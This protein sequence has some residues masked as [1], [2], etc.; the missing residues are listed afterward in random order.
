[1]TTPK[2][3][4]ARPKKAT[5]GP[6]HNM[7]LDEFD[8]LLN[9]ERG[10]PV[11]FAATVKELAVTRAQIKQLDAARSEVF[12]HVKRAYELG[13]RVVG[14]TG[15]ELR[16]T[17][18]GEPS[19]Y[20]AVAS[21]VAKKADPEAWRRAQA[22]KRWVQVKCPPAF[23]LAIPVI[24]TP[25]V[26]EFLPPDQA[27]ILYREHPAWKRRRW[28]AQDEER[29][30]GSL[31]KIA[32]EFGW[33]GGE[34]DGPVTFTDGWSVQLRTTQYS[35]ERLAETDPALFDALAETKVK[36]ASPRIVVRHAD[37]HDMDE[38]DGE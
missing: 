27:T 9:S 13:H 7:T 28:L 19:A 8:A 18:P 3:R 26:P 36:Q 5:S 31:E 29:L 33:D 21:A 23:E 15:Y 14:S 1:M 35:S 12:E 34:T 25:S 24:D 22:A 11:A 17:S 2:R 6:T 38:L 20:R 32:A 30:I 37:E 10:Y 16:Q 4:S